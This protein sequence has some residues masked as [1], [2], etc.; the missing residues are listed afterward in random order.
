I[1]G[2]VSGDGSFF[3]NKTTSVKGMFS[4]SQSVTNQ[5]VLWAIWV[6]F[7]KVG[8]V[9][10]E[11]SSPN[12]KLVVS[13]IADLINVII[14]FFDKYYILGNKSLDYADFRKVCFLIAKKEHLTEAGK[15]Q[16]LAI[17]SG[18]NSYR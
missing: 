18:M 9:S 3:I 8:G 2:F 11:K 5:H 16:C 13:G 15:T 12:S 17:R 6:Y 1:A 14:P 4:V 10:G 7:G